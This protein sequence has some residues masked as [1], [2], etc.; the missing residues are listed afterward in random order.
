MDDGAVIVARAV[1]VSRQAMTHRMPRRAGAAAFKDESAGSDPLRFAGP[2]RFEGGIAR[3][4]DGRVP[5]VEVLATV[6]EPIPRHVP[7]L[8]DALIEL[9]QLRPDST[10]VDCTIGLGG[11]TRQLL[12]AAPEGR[13]IGLDADAANLAHAADGLRDHAD[14][15]VF[16]KANFEALDAVLAELKIDEVDV[17]L[18]DLGPSSNQIDDPQR[19]LSFQADGP[20]DMRLDPDNPTTAADLVNGLPESELADLI[21]NYSQE[22]LSRRIAR[23]IHLARR[24]RRIT[25]TSHLAQIVAAAMGV[26]PSSRRSRIHPATRTFL[27]LRMAV[28]REL[29][30][31]AALLDA[32][33]SRL[34]AGG[35][36][37]VISFHSVEDRVVK[38][39]F[40][41]RRTEGVYEL[42]TRKPIV[43][44]ADERT[45]NPRSR[46]AKLRVAR[47]TPKT[48]EGEYPVVADTP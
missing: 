16:R 15:C 32:A 6:P 31:L 18:A 12:A 4:I 46:S 11:H 14:R 45:E 30:C 40:L 8:S 22:R 41:R 48:G 28:N 39:D 20:L 29:E 9:L 23:R 2:R 3:R 7:V 43:A 17:I 25:R 1:H 34:A 35:R 38:R 5:I 26:D 19:G 10:I 24:E 21:Y 36:I 44:T 37:A 33:P 42:V 13:V 47:R 27:A